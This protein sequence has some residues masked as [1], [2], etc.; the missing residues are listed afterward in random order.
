M[1]YIKWLTAAAVL[2]AIVVVPVG[3][4]SPAGAAAPLYKTVA[5]NV[6]AYLGLDQT[7][8]KCLEK[9][10]KS[11]DR[12]YN[13]LADPAATHGGANEP[14]YAGGE[15]INETNV[16]TTIYT[17]MW[18]ND[19]PCSNTPQPAAYMASLVP[20][21]F[22]PDSGGPP[23]GVGTLPANTPGGNPTFCID[24]ANGSGPCYVPPAFFTELFGIQFYAWAGFVW[25]ETPPSCQLSG[26]LPGFTVTDT[27]CYWTHGFDSDGNYW[28]ASTT[29][30][31]AY[32]VARDLWTL[33]IDW[34]GITYQL[35]TYWYW[36]NAYNTETYEFGCNEC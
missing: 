5:K 15:S 29:P 33:N 17:Q 19:G 30:N 24:N 31:G 10:G 23:P 9:A 3:L 4:A 21:T 14:S 1:R 28:E 18:K 13:A 22:A 35:H 27:Q 32:I 25:E 8:E 2:L 12:Q 11:I 16:L 6:A 36:Y 7:A 34:A 26:L 20:A